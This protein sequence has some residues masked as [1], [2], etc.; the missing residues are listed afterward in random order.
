MSK[1]NSNNHTIETL[2]SAHSSASFTL[3]EVISAA[4]R[5]F[6]EGREY[7]TP[8]PPTGMYCIF[9]GAE[10]TF[11]KIMRH[12]TSCLLWPHEMK[13]TMTPNTKPRDAERLTHKEPTI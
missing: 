7:G 5:P 13:V 12:D 8:L 10:A 9:C 3:E 6:G 4:L 11:G 1:Q 2:P